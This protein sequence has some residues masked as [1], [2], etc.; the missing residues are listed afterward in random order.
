MRNTASQS[1]RA[2]ERKQV[3]SKGLYG[4]YV[5]ERQVKKLTA[6]GLQMAYRQY[7]EYSKKKGAVSQVE[8]DEYFGKLAWVLEDGTVLELR[9]NA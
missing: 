3:Q 8:N 1:A 2:S 6:S 9:R 5:G 4:V 7:N